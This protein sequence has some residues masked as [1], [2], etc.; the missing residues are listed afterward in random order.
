MDTL[1]EDLL[2]AY[3]K[4]LLNDDETPVVG[5]LRVVHVQVM[6]DSRT[7]RVLGRMKWVRKDSLYS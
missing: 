5:E 7:M 2:I 4:N 3:D 1:E 6:E